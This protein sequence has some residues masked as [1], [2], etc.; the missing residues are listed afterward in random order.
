VDYNT[1]QVVRPLT[2]QVA[3]TTPGGTYTYQWYEAGVAITGA[4]S[5]TYDVPADPTGATRIYTVKMTSVNPP[6][7]GC[8]NESDPFTVLQSGQA[9]AIGVGY[10]V[11]NA[12]F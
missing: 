10:E 6:Q 2:L 5:S 8:E 1:Q 9:V 4:T 11:S 12:F 3:S 7:L